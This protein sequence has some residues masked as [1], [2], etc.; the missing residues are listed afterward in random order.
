MQ[1]SLQE[2]L[3]CPTRHV[4]C[5]LRLK[6]THV[7]EHNERFN[8]HAQRECRYHSSEGGRVLREGIAEGDDVTQLCVC[9]PSDVA[10]ICINV[11]SRDVVIGDTGLRC[12][13]SSDPLTVVARD[14]STNWID[15]SGL[16]SIH[17]GTDINIC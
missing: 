8:A 2:R 16:T 9:Q 12:A 6:A 15:G 10:A 5:F 1:P 14:G 4:D 3:S 13:I 7:L 11:E 17:A